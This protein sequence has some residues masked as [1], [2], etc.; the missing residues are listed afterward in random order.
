MRLVGFIL[1]MAI[2]S[3]G[4]RSAFFIGEEGEYLVVVDK[5]VPTDPGA[6]TLYTVKNV[7][8]ESRFM[9]GSRLFNVHSRHVFHVGDTVQLY[10][11]ESPKRRG[12]DDDSEIS[13]EVKQSLR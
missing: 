12:P 11:L 6:R 4:C 9:S 5:K 1:L 10:H 3:S 7:T 13:D 2:L 8:Q